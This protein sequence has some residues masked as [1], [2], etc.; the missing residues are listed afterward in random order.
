MGGK[1][2]GSTA[3]GGHF[4]SCASRKMSTVAVTET[5]YTFPKPVAWPY[6]PLFEKIQY[7]KTILDAKYVPFVDKLEA[8]QQVAALCPEVQTAAVVKVLE[9]PMDLV[10]SD[11]LQ[12]QP[13]LLKA[14]HGCGWNHILSPAD[15]LHTL[16]TMLAGWQKPY[17]GDEK[18]YT[19]LKPR[20]FIETIVDDVYTGK[21]GKAR[22]FMIRCIHG[23]PVSV[24][25]RAGNDSVVQN[26]YN[27]DFTLVEPARFAMEKPVQ[28]EAMLYYA[29]KLS[30]SFEFVRIDF[31]LAT[32]GNVY[33]SEFT[34][35]P[36]GGHRVFSLKR[37]MELGRLWV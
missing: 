20:F 23:K 6:M 34:F 37:E 29:T 33:F 12:S 14:T 1:G 5:S 31:Y 7:Y 21:S 2:Q 8:K 28:W 10:A 32:C 24:G 30:A 27:T 11:L 9:A 35:T 17:S 36:A 19:Y 13:C 15:D 22:V 18:Q 3:V 4:L 26:S 25:V 16:Q